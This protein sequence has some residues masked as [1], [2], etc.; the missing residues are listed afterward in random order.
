M[1]FL[2]DYLF[3]F[4]VGLVILVVFLFRYFDILGML[5]DK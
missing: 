4:N 3:I 5:E 1:E 2:E